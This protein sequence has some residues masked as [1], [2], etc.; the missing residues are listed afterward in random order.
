MIRFF[1]I[2]LFFTS[3]N[4]VWSIE[5]KKNIDLKNNWLQLHDSEWVPLHWKDS[6]KVKVAGVE[7]PQGAHD[8]FVFNNY[9]ITDIYV[10]NHFYQRT[11]TLGQIILPVKEMEN[12]AHSRHLFIT[13]FAEKGVL[14]LTQT[15]LGKEKE[16][17]LLTGNSLYVLIPRT[18]NTLKDK[19]LIVFYILVFSLVFMKVKHGKIFQ[20]YFNW[21]NMIRNLPPE[22]NMV[23]SVLNK[24]SIYFIMLMS[25]IIG[26]E[27]CLFFSIDTRNDAFHGRNFIGNLIVFSF[28]A[29]MIAILKYYFLKL[30]S[31]LVGA[32]TYF[33]RHYF[34]Y[35]RVIYSI[36]LVLLLP[37]L[38]IYLKGGAFPFGLKIFFIISC[39]L[40]VFRI[41]I[42]T[43]RHVKFSF[44][45]LFSYICTSE[46]VPILIV[47][48]FLF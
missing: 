43:T 27:I 4:S 46:I 41:F 10:N 7:L 38:I 23:A 24:P 28:I 33:K 1:Y 13:V 26:L 6:A 18:F 2:L 19:V 29:F 15:Y 17:S 11:K 25:G 3:I 22:E 31:S 20:G 12:I 47:T 14:S 48:K 8:L 35:L 44:L 21:F 36:S 30:F 32:T 37:L 40:G 42:L 45:Y 9:G 5:L 16:P 34:E 39:F